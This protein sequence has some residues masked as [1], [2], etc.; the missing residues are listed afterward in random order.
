M[1]QLINF[2]AKRKYIFLFLFIQL[3]TLWLTIQNKDYHKTTFI[4]STGN[5]VGS[6]YSKANNLEKYLNL[7]EEN[8][9]LAEENAKLHSML[10]TSM[11][12][13]NSFFDSRSD[14]NALKIVQKYQFTESE[15]IN[16]SYRHRNNHIT[17]NK[18]LLNG[19]N[20][21]DGVITY[22]GIIGV[23]E[24]VGENYSSVISILNKN[25]QVN[26]KLKK[27]N[28]FGSLSWPGAN[29]NKLLLSDIP[30]EAQLNIGDTIVTGG[31][32]TIFPE[33]INIGIIDKFE[34]LDNQ[35]YYNIVVKPFI[36]YAN[37]KSVYVV[38]NLKREQIKEVE[39]KR[40]D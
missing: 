17:I 34:I 2:L 13:V 7:H 20:D 35:N 3:I 6:I 27:S 32:S 11:I 28:Y 25:L 33:G 4:N 31:Y 5:F 1:Q 39:S 21:G 37:I 8:L 19:I 12:E 18:G 15:I 29:R 24:S 10:A 22:N 14:T 26:A 38:K 36:D 30:K 40:K 9:R 16:N 23:I